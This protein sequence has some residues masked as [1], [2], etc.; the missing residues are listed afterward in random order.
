MASATNPSILVP[1]Q[2]TKVKWIRFV[3]TQTWRYENSRLATDAMEEVTQVV[4]LVSYDQD[5]V[6]PGV[7]LCASC[8]HVGWGFG[9]TNPSV[10]DARGHPTVTPVDASALVV[11]D[12]HLSVSTLQG[13]IVAD[14]KTKHQREPTSTM[15]D[16]KVIAYETR[17]R[18]RPTQAFWLGLEGLVKY[19]LARG[20]TLSLT[21]QGQYRDQSPPNVS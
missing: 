21:L 19:Q 16:V 11:Y 9:H 14:F 20:M 1:Q 6:L 3:H 8:H 2:T 18:P 4:P 12:S 13:Q 15:A 10:T 17:Q 5:P 7:Y